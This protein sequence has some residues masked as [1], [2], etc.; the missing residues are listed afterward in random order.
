VHPGTNG[1]GTDQEEQLQVR[2]TSH[3]VLGVGRVDVLTR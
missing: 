2:E 3:Y 1:T